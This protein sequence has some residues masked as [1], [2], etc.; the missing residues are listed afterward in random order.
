MAILRTGADAVSFVAPDDLAAL[1]ADVVVT[2]G[3]GDRGGRG[4]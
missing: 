2:A 1:R 4:R 3:G